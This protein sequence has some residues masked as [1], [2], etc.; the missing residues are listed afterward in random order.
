MSSS[1]PRTLPS[2][3]CSAC[4]GQRPGLKSGHSA[5]R[6]CPVP[7]HPDTDDGPV[8]DVEHDRPHDL[9]AIHQHGAWLPVEDGGCRTPC[10]FLATWSRNSS[11]G[12]ADHGRMAART[13]RHHRSR[14]RRHRRAWEESRQV[15]GGTGHEKAVRQARPWRRSASKNAVAAPRPVAVG[16]ELSW[17]Q[18]A[19]EALN[20]R[21]HLLEGI[22]ENVVEQIRGP[23]ERRHSDVVSRICPWVAQGAPR[24]AVEGQVAGPD[25]PT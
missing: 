5:A 13:C 21:A 4:E 25:R 12:G 9:A 10:T 23:L 3:G 15:A 22:A 20:E 24:L 7:H 14:R 16:A 17:R 2:R 1:A 11:C 8:H 18:A 19:G 6:A